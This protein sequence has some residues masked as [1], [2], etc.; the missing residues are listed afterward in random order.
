MFCMR[1]LD[2]ETSRDESGRR[3]RRRRE[4]R[5]RMREVHAGGMGL[6][7]DSQSRKKVGRLR[8]QRAQSSL[9]GEER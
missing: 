2:R 1:G 6:D 4:R 7:P 3:E 5:K 8:R 9:Y